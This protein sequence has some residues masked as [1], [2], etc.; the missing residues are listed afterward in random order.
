ML[1]EAWRLQRDHFWRA[2]MSKVDWKAALQRYVPLVE[3]VNCRS[4]FNDL[5]LEMQGE[6]G[7][8]HAYSSGGDHRETPSYPVGFL[9]ADLAWD[10]AAGGYRVDGFLRG[11]P[12]AANEACP[13]RAPGVQFETGSVITAVNGHKLSATVTPHQAL[14]QQ[15]GAEVYLSVKTEDSTRQVRVRT[16]RSEKTPVTGTGLNATAIM[17]ARSP[18]AALATST[19]PTWVRAALLSFTAISYATMIATA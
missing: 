7:T 19:S 2:D 1:H 16:L 12:W 3:R 15:A 5:V 13:L 8:S 11:D 14:M 10:D 9:G 17:S 6:L 4:E 18:A